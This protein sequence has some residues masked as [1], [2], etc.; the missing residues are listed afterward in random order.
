MYNLQDHKFD[1]LL[2]YPGRFSD[3]ETKYIIRN[4]LLSLMQDNKG[5]NLNLNFAKKELI[6]LAYKISAIASYE[7]Y[8]RAQINLKKILNNCW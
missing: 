8:I 5:I 7:N 1:L 4:K 3:D 6:N 2:K